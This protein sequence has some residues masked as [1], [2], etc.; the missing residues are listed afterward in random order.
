M[1]TYIVDSFTNVAFKGNPAGVCLIDEAISEKRMQSI[2]TE[3][4]FSETAF[5]R[6]LEG[7][8]K[9]AIRFFSPK[10]EIPLC[11][12]ATLACSKVLFE[13]NEFDSIHFVNKNKLDLYIKRTREKIV[14]EFP[15]YEVHPAE[16]PPA[17]LKALGLKE[18]EKV[19]FNKET[20]I[21][22]LEIK[23]TE[24]L[25]N[26]QPDFVAMIKAHD[27]IDGVLV[28]APAN[29]GYDFHSRYFWPWAG[30]DEDP[31]TGAT[32][33]FLT[34]YWGERLGKKQLRSFQA[35]ARSGFMDLE[36]TDKNKL[37]IKAEAVIVL[38]GELLI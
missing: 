5:V 9:Y 6:P 10:K 3:M 34:K 30:G 14:M 31:V 37:L 20:D 32:H 25:K 29:D 4:G 38:K 12:H 8:N 2:A 15:I 13:E 21:L 23:S 28:T 1:R 18:V 22:I 7:K 26:L 17:L 27:P 35:S 33:T 19:S 11:G 24:I 16:V 36:I